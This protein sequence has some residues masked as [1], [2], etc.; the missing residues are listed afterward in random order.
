MNLFTRYKKLFLVIG[1]IA[2]TIFLGFLLYKTFFSSN[3][4]IT[5]ETINNATS[6]SGLPLSGN[7]TGQIST[8]TGTG[9]LTGNENIINISQLN[10]GIYLLKIR[11]SNGQTVTQ[12]IV[13][14]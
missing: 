6:T 3:L 11:L 8:S 14:Q 4:A 1:F 10:T 13:K 2:I 12:R 9:N 7:G 5:P